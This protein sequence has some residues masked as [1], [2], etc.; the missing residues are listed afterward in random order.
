MEEGDHTNVIWMPGDVAHTPPSANSQSAGRI[1]W[2]TSKRASTPSINKTSN[3]SLASQIPYN[4]VPS[5]AGS[6]KNILHVMIPSYRGNFV[7]F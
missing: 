1:P 7:E 2:G 4:G 6:S 5:A 3:L